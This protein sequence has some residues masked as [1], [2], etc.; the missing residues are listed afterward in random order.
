MFMS[1]R[2]HTRDFFHQSFSNGVQRLRNLHSLKDTCC[3][4]D[5][6]EAKCKAVEGTGLKIFNANAATLSSQHGNGM[7]RILRSY[8][9]LPSGSLC[10]A[11]QEL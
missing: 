5:Q 4:L 8:G 9:K 10:M 1:A 7:C 6:L 3:D 11:L 2:H